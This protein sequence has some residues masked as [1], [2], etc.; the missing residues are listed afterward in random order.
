MP[1]V[2]STSIAVEAGRPDERPSIAAVEV[3]AEVFADALAA[4]LGTELAGFG[5]TET[6]QPDVLGDPLAAGR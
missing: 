5:A 1:G 4:R 2:V 6:A 3:A